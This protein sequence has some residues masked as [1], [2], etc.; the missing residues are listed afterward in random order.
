MRISSFRLL[1]TALQLTCRIGFPPAPE[2][3]RTLARLDS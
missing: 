2:F 3:F 1:M